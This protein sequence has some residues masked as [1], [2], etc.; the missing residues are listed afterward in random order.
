MMKIGFIQSDSDAQ[1]GQVD[2]GQDATMN[3]ENRSVDTQTITALMSNSVRRGTWEPAELVQVYCVM[4]NV[5]LDFYDAVLLGD[6]TEIE[7]QAIM[8]SVKIYVPDD[9][10]VE[11]EGTGFMGS[12][13][14]LNQTSIEADSPLLRIAGFALMSSV[15]IV[16]R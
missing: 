3:S 8:G 11:T 4:G 1:A 16:Q 2:D 12:F 14:H 5:E 9:I 10:D 15:E 13:E 6:V 7:I